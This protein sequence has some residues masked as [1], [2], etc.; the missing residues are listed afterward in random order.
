MYRLRQWGA[1]KQNVSHLCEEL[2]RFGIMRP[3]LQDEISICETRGR[4]Y[5]HLDESRNAKCDGRLCVLETRENRIGGGNDGW[6]YGRE[7]CH[8]DTGGK[9]LGC[10]LIRFR[11]AGVSLTG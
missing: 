8:D 10:K 3:G 5:A 7:N 2:D 9:L 11:I 6:I 1:S 4:F